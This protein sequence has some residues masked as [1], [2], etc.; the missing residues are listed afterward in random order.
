MHVVHSEQIARSSWFDRQRAM[1]ATEAL[2]LAD[3]RAVRVAKHGDAGQGRVELR[4]RKVITRIAE[5]QGPRLVKGATVN[6][7]PECLGLEAHFS[8]LRDNMTI[9]D[10]MRIVVRVEA[11]AAWLLFGGGVDG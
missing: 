4:K 6:D 8:T 10:D 1:D 9:C 7:A 3:A 11:A 5:D 2:D